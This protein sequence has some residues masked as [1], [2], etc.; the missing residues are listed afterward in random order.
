MGRTKIEWCDHSWNPFVG[1]TAV[2]TG[3]AH[4]YAR[5]LHEQRYEAFRAGK[6]M[7][8]RYYGR[9]FADVR[10]VD[11]GR[12]FDAPLSWKGRR[13][14]FVN[15][16]SDTFHEQIEDRA[17]L[18]LLAAAAVTARHTFILL[19]K[20]PRRA[21]EFFDKYSPADAAEAGCALDGKLKQR[22]NWDR[23]WRR[24][25]V[26]PLPNVWLGTSIENQEAVMLRLPWLLAT[27]AAV[28]FAS[29]EPLLG[30]VD[31]RASLY[32]EGALDW[33]VAGAETGM[34]A[35]VMHAD[36]ARW[37]RDQCAG[38]KVPFFFKKDSQGRRE[39]DGQVIE[40][41]PDEM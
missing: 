30:P 4:C 5:R 31:V 3:C 35:R 13:R 10:V 21:F 20:R 15:S 6:G 32:G 1:C 37:L 39:L 8:E 25:P 2:S 19:T 17:I 16:M 18:A 12:V 29:A 24:W 40:Q 11:E 26:W 34:D 22:L 38:A 41:W 28:R 36:W 9:P 7:S 27:P 33:I 23:I 14:V